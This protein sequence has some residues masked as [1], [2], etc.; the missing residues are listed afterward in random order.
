MYMEEE[1]DLFTGDE[2]G[3][4]IIPEGRLD[5]NVTIS[6]FF[7]ADDVPISQYPL[8]NDLLKLKG[9]TDSKVTIIG[10]DGEEEVV[11]FP[12]L[13]REEQL[14]I[15]SD[16]ESNVSDELD[17]SEINLI[18][19]LRENNLT[20]D[21]WKEQY[22]QEVL[23]AAALTSPAERV[24]DIDDYDN[25]ELFLLDLK[26]KYDL[27]DEELVSELEK[28]LLNEELFTKK[29]A[30][31]REE[32]KQLEDQYKTSQLEETERQRGFEYDKFANKM[33]DIATRTNEFH[34]IELEDNDKNETLAYL[35][36]LDD[37][38]LSSFYKELNNPEKL[39]EAAWYLRYG[40]EAF[41]ALKNAYETE[42]IKLKKIDKPRVVVQNAKKITSIHDFI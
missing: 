31:L 28:E 11:D 13:S 36:E 3:E 5:E 41:D 30:K 40:K 26:N 7:G 38:G 4:D 8:V 6:D 15:L 29:T 27:T 39:Y 24:Y 25:Q 9:I 1:D 37:K 16:Q 20:I 21:E 19:Q 2:T 17:E 34:G 23:N 18:N 33:V 12:T 10:E 32:Y 35:L 22:R 14:G 42:I